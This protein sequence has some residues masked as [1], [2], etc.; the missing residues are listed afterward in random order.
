MKQI[1]ILSLK[2]KLVA[3][4][5]AQQVVIYPKCFKNVSKWIREFT[6]SK[7][8]TFNLALPDMTLKKIHE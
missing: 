6:N 7:P 3:E 5:D 2:L 1:A 8:F 4:E